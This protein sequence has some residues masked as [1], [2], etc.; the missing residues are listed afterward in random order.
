MVRS[1]LESLSSF[2]RY[3]VILRGKLF[4]AML[5]LPS[6][7]VAPFGFGVR[8]VEGEP[9]SSTLRWLLRLLVVEPVHTP[10]IKKRALYDYISASQIS[11]DK[12]DVQN[13]DNVY[14]IRIVDH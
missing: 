6:W 8:E 1:T 7:L 12:L 5:A 11:G 4:I 2:Q 14:D 10:H 3:S 13:C 9:I